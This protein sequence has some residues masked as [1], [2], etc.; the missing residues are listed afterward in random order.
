MPIPSTWNLEAPPGC[1]GMREDRPIE[2]YERHLLHWRQEGATYFVTFR[3]ADSLPKAK[4]R[5][6]ESLRRELANRPDS[7]RE[8]LARETARR[9]ERWLDQG[10]GECLLRARASR[11]VVVNSLRHFDG[12]RYGLG[13]FVVM[14]NHVHAIVRPFTG[15]RLESIV[16]SWKRFTAIEINRGLGRSGTLWQEEA[17][18]RIVR[19][20]EHL[21]RIL[22]YIGRNPRLAG[23]ND[24][25]TTRWVSSQWVENGWRFEDLTRDNDGR[26]EN[27]SYEESCS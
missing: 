24:T 10:S 23:L 26:I 16:Q 11:D 7:T 12:D 25:S 19:D 15:H 18:D 17:F 20:E 27:P 3:L 22:Q 4:L 6:L 9:V 1:Q 13:A 14:P 8:E 21:W 5:E 2:F